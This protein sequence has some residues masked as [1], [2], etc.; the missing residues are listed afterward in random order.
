[1][2]KANPRQLRQEVASLE[3]G[4]ARLEVTRLKVVLIFLLDLGLVLLHLLRKILRVQ[5]W[6]LL[7]L[8]WLAVVHS[9]FLAASRCFHRC[10][11]NNL[12]GLLSLVVLLGHWLLLN[13][14]GV[15]IVLSIVVHG[16]TLVV[17][18][19]AGLLFLRLSYLLPLG[20][21]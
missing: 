17:L 7:C 14:A 6:H 15:L 1:M 13:P 16:H 18:V 10:L 12:F 20:V 21:F 8:R 4:S 19:N 3:L 11:E 5:W 2:L 9:D